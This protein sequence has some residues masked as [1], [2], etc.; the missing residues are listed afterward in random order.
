MLATLGPL[1]AGS[2]FQL[3]TFTAKIDT[4][5]WFLSLNVKTSSETGPSVTVRSKL[6]FR[7]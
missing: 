2:S 6:E 3:V 7:T 5:H 4:T 1:F